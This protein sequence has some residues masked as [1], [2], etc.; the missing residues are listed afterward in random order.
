MPNGSF[1]PSSTI[2]KECIYCK[3]CQ[4]NKLISTKETLSY[5]KYDIASY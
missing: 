3:T 2:E 4:Y 1:M 5:P